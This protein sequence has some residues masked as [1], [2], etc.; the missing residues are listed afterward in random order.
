MLKNISFLIATCGLFA[1][2]GLPAY[3]DDSGLAQT[4]HDVRRESG[5]LCQIDHWHYGSGVGSTKKAAMND[6][7]GSWQSFTAL[8]YG[9]DWSRFQRSASKNVSCSNSGGGGVSC[10]IEGRPCR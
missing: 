10:S 1:V 3:A 7:I 2:V 5:K 6:A 8:E 9:S 4:I